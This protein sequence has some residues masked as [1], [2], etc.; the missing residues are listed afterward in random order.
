MSSG[1]FSK[2]QALSY[3]QAFKARWQKFIHSHFESPEHV[4]FTFGVDATTARNWWEGSN[5]PSGFA[6]GMAYERFP[7]EAA[8]E[9]RG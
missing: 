3:R 8:R 4:A 9:L 2:Q 6:V 7:S 5:A 1:K